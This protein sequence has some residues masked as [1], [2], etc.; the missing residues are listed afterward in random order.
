MSICTRMLVAA[1]VVAVSCQTAFAQ[2]RGGQ[3][4]GIAFIDVHNHLFGRIPGQGAPEFD[5]RGAVKTATANMEKFGIARMLVMP[6]PLSP[7]NAKAFNFKAFVRTV[8]K[9]H[10]RFGFLAG[11]ASLNV[12]IHRIPARRSRPAP[13]P[14]SRRR[15][16]NSSPKAR[17]DRLQ[18]SG[19]YRGPSKTQRCLV[20][21][22]GWYEWK[23]ENGAKQPAR[24]QRIVPRTASRHYKAAGR[25]TH[26]ESRI[27]FS[28][29]AA[30]GRRISP[31]SSC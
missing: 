22:T 18:K 29:T 7:E 8:K 27:P 9:H 6:P 12:M 3:M 2:S 23:T 11:G 24:S 4:D 25:A 19:A 15:P 16:T 14:N 13:V 30:A 5:Y 31:A 28:S 20:P 26:G 1:V 21:A 17:S 10:D